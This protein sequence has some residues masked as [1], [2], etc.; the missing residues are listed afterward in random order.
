MATLYDIGMERA[1]G[2][3]HLS[4][5]EAPATPSFG[6]GSAWGKL[7]ENYTSGA[8]TPPPVTGAP[9]EP[10]AGGSPWDRLVAA[11][12]AR[13]AR[14]P[15]NGGA[16]VT[17]DYVVQG[18]VQRGLPEHVA[19]GFA[20]NFK[21]ESGL[22]PGI[23]EIEPLVEG[24]RGGY[25]LYQLTGPRRRQYE[26]MATRMGR[27]FSDPDLQ[28]DF[29]VHELQTTEKRAGERIMQ[30]GNAGEAGA[31]IVNHFLRPSPEYRAT[32]ANRYLGRS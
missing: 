29:L 4:A 26:E 1:T 5:G 25:G 20:M 3:K 17:E 9:V 8:P 13:P 15:A 19:R 7:L 30:A 6:E 23:N 24:S 11:R 31:A 10:A 12:A 28:M 27:D 18:L 22:D 2:G 14:P 21:D 16:P 32:R